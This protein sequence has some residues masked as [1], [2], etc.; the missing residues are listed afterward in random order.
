MKKSKKF[1]LAGLVLL[2]ITMVLLPLSG[3]KN[4]SVP[5]PTRYT[6]K[7]D[8][9]DNSEYTGDLP[10]DITVESG[11]KLTAEQLKGLADTADYI[12]EGWYDGKTKAEGGT[13]TVTKDVTLEAKWRDRGTVAS[14]AFTPAGGALDYGET[15]TLSSQE[16][17]TIHY[18]VNDG[19][20]KTGDSPVTVS[21]T[22]DTTITAKATKDGFKDSEETEATYT[23]KQYTVT[24]NT[25]GK[26]TKTETVESG[27][28]ATR[29]EP[30]PTKDGWVFAGWYT[31]KDDGETLADTA[32]SFDTPV[33]DDITLYAAWNGVGDDGNIVLRNK[34][35]SKTSE[36]QVLST[37]VYLKDLY[38]AASNSRIFVENRVGSIQPFVMGQYEVT[39]QL[40]FA[41]MGKWGGTEPS[42]TYGKGDEYPAYYV[43]WYDAVVFCNELTKKVLDDGDCVYYSDAGLTTV[44]TTGDVTDGNPPYMDISKSGYRLPTEAEWEYAARAGDDTTNARTWSGTKTEADLENYAWYSKNSGNEAGE[45]KKTHQVG[46]L[47]PNE[48]GLH[49]M[50]GN[51]WEWC[52]DWYDGKYYSSSTES[53]TNPTG[54]TGGSSGDYRVFRGGCWYDNA[55]Y[56]TV[57]YRS[58]IDPY[59]RSFDLGFRLVRS[60][61]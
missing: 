22:G 18:T 12:F 10:A 14:V 61:N 17:A 8:K 1:V 34:V 16:G 15:V 26:D 42:N 29:P 6:V 19:E 49:D 44:Y 28:T 40:Y 51:V 58:G 52:W 35:M 47:D 20:E 54:P 30:D 21:V 36:V 13:Y 24:F 60:A 53:V 4:D 46:T 39:Q 37:A 2:A 48:W 32:Y 57:S 5:E 11:T 38:N 31:L 45:E 59:Y 25:D 33:E 50:T 7:F 3:C 9:G 55:D 43:S 23:L 56:C 27:Q 41:V